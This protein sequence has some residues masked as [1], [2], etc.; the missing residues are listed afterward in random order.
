MPIP[1]DIYSE[2]ITTLGE[3]LQART[4]LINEIKEGVEFWESHM[5]DVAN[6]AKSIAEALKLPPPLVDRIYKGGLL[7]DM[8]KSMFEMQSA[9]MHPGKLVGP[10]L[11]LVRQHT[12]YG[13][14]VVEFAFGITDPIV[15]AIVKSHHEKLNGNG[16][17]EGLRG[18][19]ISQP[20]RITTVADICCAITRD[21]PTAP[22]RSR[23]FA[24]SV[25][26]EEADAGE[27]DFYLVETL[28]VDV[29]G[30]PARPPKPT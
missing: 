5:D 21:R 30:F 4:N 11:E 3:L 15:L 13:V 16:Y 24:V 9:L 22:A 20:V 18:H 12:V 25:L 8:G 23:E 14:Q 26:R 29:F 7:H 19:Q 27:L 10:Q 28:A 1:E 6:I 17:P 2:N